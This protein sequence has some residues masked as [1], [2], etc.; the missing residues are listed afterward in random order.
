MK[1][2]DVLDE[3]L[4]LDISVLTEDGSEDLS[5]PIAPVVTVVSV[6][7]EEESS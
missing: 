4:Y 2:G 5:R 7:E 3:N 1:A 6:Q